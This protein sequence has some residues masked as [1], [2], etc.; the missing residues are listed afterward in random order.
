MWPYEFMEFLTTLEML[1]QLATHRPI[2]GLIGLLF[3]V[4]LLAYIL[5]TLGED[6]DLCVDFFWC[7]RFFS[8]ARHPKGL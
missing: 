6:Y 8:I 3:V 2:A 7:L 1:H 4:K 5:D